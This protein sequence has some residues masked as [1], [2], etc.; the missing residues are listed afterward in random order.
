V[1]VFGKHVYSAYPDPEGLLS[2]LP[3]ITTTLIGLLVGRALRS[4]KPIAKRCAQ[5]LIAGV[6]LAATGVTI[7][8]VGI[9]INKQIWT[10]SYAVLSAG[11]ACLGLGAMFYAI[12][13]RGRRR[14]AVPLVA[15]GTNAILI[16][17]LSGAI[18][19]L[20]GLVTVPPTWLPGAVDATTRPGSIGVR[21]VLTAWATHLQQAATPTAWH[22]PEAASLAYAVGFLAAVWLV[23]ACCTGCGGS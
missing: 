21:A 1:A 3:A 18:S 23:A 22:T 4:D 6:A 12:D 9:P 13:V 10:P 20:M 15:L 19:R 5:M 16:F 2:T 7:G 8:W 11:L 17:L 14:P